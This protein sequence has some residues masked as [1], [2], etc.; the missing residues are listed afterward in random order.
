[1]AYNIITIR[2]VVKL[3]YSNVAVSAWLLLR[4]ICLCI[5]IY[6]QCVLQLTMVRNCCVGRC[7]SK[8]DTPGVHL[9]QFPNKKTDEPRW[10]NWK[11][12]VNMTRKDF[13]P[14]STS[15]ICS[16]HFIIP[17]DYGN[18]NEYNHNLKTGRWVSFFRRKY[19]SILVWW[20]HLVITHCSSCFFSEAVRAWSFLTSTVW[21][22]DISDLP[23]K[24]Y[25]I[26]VAPRLSNILHLN[27]CLFCKVSSAY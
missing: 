13:Q 10:R 6:D 23:T 9:H 25:I 7:N 18:I 26:K 15:S 4:V 8:A 24:K 3:K 5:V 2:S 22:Q 12:F 19:L 11:T 17:D 16:N 14:S 1:M 27:F 21:S 20:L